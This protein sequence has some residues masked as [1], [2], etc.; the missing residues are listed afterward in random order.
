MYI[1]QSKNWPNF[2]FQQEKLDYKLEV[3]T[4]LQ[5]KLIGRARDLP[6]NLDQLAEMDA[7][8]QNA[9]QLATEKKINHLPD[10]IIIEAIEIFK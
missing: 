2:I 4:G 9:L 5:K 7:L 3:V 6:E 10:N 8:I 1:W